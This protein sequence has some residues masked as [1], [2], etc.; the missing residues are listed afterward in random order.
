MKEMKTSKDFINKGANYFIN[1]D[2]ELKRTYK[3]PNHASVVI[4][5]PLK[6]CVKP[7]GHRVWD[8]QNIS[9]YIPSGWIHLF[10][11]VKDGEANFVK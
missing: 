7:N 3:F 1:I 11:E 5:N 8:A 10:W 9:H 4:N 6:L 2:S